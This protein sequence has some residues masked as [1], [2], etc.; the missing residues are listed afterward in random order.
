[1]AVENALMIGGVQHGKVM[2]HHKPLAP[3]IR[4]Q[5]IIAN[6]QT[7][8]T[9]PDYKLVTTHECQSY[10]LAIMQVG[11]GPHPRFSTGYMYVVV[12]CYI[13]ESIPPEHQQ[14]VASLELMSWEKHRLLEFLWETFIDKQT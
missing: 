6:P 8:H 2:G 3:V 11:I 14:R 13:H 5:V 7:H 10:S 1:M 12:P 9:K 4:E